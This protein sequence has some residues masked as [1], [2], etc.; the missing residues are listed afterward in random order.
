LK[1]SAKLETLLELLS[2]CLLMLLSV[3]DKINITRNKRNG[4]P[5]HSILRL[6]WELLIQTSCLSLNSS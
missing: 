1:E 5:Q 6:C 3:A 4:R 2:I